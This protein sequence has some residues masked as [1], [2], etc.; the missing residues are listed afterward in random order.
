M[1][2]VLFAITA[3]AAL[4]VGCTKDKENTATDTPIAFRAS[5]EEP[6]IVMGQSSKSYSWVEND[7]VGIFVN[8]TREMVFK[9]DQSAS[10]TSLSAVMADIP[11]Y[12]GSV[13]YAYAPATATSDVY[14]RTTLPIP[15]TQQFANGRNLNVLNMA[16]IAPVE[17]AAAEF[18][19]KQLGA[20]LELGLKSPDAD[21]SL[22]KMKIEVVN[23]SAGKYM[24]GRAKIDF[25]GSEPELASTITGGLNS[26]TVEFA[27]GITLSQTPVFIPIGVLPFAT[28]GG[29]LQVT[30]YDQENNT[31]VLPKI[32][33]GDNEISENGAL[34]ISR[35]VRVID[36]LGDVLYENFDRPES[37]TI[38][39]MDDRTGAVRA[40]Q[41]VDVYA[42]A[43]NIETKVNTF[44]SDAS[45]L[46]KTALNPGGYR[47]YCAYD[48]TT[49][50]KWNQLDLSVVKDGGNTFDFVIYPILFADDFSWV[51]PEMG[52]SIVLKELYES[53]NP[54]VANTA[55]EVVWAS[56]VGVSDILTQKG[57]TFS[58]WVY[59]RP[60]SARVGKKSATGTMTTPKLNAISS[61]TAKLTV[62]AMPWHVVT[63]GAWK[64]EEAEL[65]FQIIGGGSF[66]AGENVT[67][68][69][70]DPMTSD[71]PA[72]PLKKNI[73]ELPIYN[74]TSNTQVS[75]TNKLPAGLSTTMYRVMI[76]QVKIVE[77][78]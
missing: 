39:V 43:G 26:I 75:I 50:A 76:D 13:A 25:T 46:V 44:T 3:L 78:R 52:G 32:W 53:I 37:V 64:L 15:A 63:G 12:Y 18:H 72:S 6:K 62:V 74:A 47:A 16:A 1:K 19:F 77:V 57:W 67:S 2:K 27:E 69:T 20:I 41:S 29:G 31:C 7:P 51:T 61:T 11:A 49:A 38:R 36:V 23:P 58:T 68:Y 48:A 73:F 54:P 45:G 66:S 65:V 21:I 30:V 33:T 55:N 5:F 17:S 40:N 35:G 8:A 70:T 59:I 24:S 10:S 4:A 60:G 71:A 28:D 22:S 42:V 34:T 56:G 9:A 14:F